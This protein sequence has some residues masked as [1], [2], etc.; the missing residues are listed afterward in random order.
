MQDLQGL[1]IAL[2][3]GCH[4]APKSLFGISVEENTPYSLPSAMVSQAPDSSRLLRAPQYPHS[5]PRVGL[6]GSARRDG[7]PSV[8]RAGSLVT[9]GHWHQLCS[10]IAP[11]A[12]STGGRPHAG[13]STLPCCTE[14]ERT[15]HPQP[16]PG[17][18]AASPQPRCVRE[19][20]SQVLGRSLAHEPRLAGALRP[21]ATCS[22]PPGGTLSP[23][24]TRVH[25][26]VWNPT[27]ASRSHSDPTFY[28]ANGG[29]IDCFSFFL[30][31]NQ[32]TQLILEQ[33]GFELR[34]FT[35]VQIFSHCRSTQSEVG[36]IRGH[37]LSRYSRIFS[38]R[39]S[40]P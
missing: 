15:Q 23:G 6:P 12:Q 3:G 21:A 36:W 29:I 13:T 25:T 38:R 33:Q 37:G 14:A 24:E 9:P 7:R 31:L 1:P 39:G 5:D 27:Q 16:R 40:A 17:P 2:P 30:S 18:Q 26:A 10:V 19:Q 28:V 22:E 35:S 20:V 34:G 32:G 11:E 8:Q 4:L